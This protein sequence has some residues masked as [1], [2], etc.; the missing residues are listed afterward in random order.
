[1]F[2]LQQGKI[3]LK[4]RKKFISAVRQWSKLSRE[5]VEW[6]SLQRIKEIPFVRD[7]FGIIK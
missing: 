1:M 7:G 4:I 5:V 6:P 2:K 3:R